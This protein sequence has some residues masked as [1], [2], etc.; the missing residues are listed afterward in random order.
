MQ[1]ASV[2]FI[3]GSVFALLQGSAS[4]FAEGL[5]SATFVRGNPGCE[6]RRQPIGIVRVVIVRAA[7]RIHIAKIVRVARIH[8]TEPPISGGTGSGI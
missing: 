4:P 3:T 2:A 7:V 8:G 1:E 6:I 5:F